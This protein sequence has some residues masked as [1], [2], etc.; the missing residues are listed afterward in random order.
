M[1]LQAL[2]LLERGPILSQHSWAMVSHLPEHIA[3]R[4]LKVI[5]RQL[6][7]PGNMLEV[8]QVEAQGPGNAVTVLIESENVTEVFVGIDER[9]VRAETVA[10]GV[11]TAVQRY[12][13]AWVPVGEYLADQLLLPLALAGGGSFITLRPSR[14]TTTNIAVIEQFTGMQLCCEK[15]GHDRWRIS[16]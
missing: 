9:G 4:E 3:Q 14:H 16:C 10:A 1:T 8:H 7:L 2:M 13:A 15:I 12:L 5:G 6:G 11:V